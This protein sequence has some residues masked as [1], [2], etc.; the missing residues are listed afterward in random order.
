MLAFPGIFRGALDA[1]AKTINQKMKMDAALA[2]SKCV[3]KPR[4]DRIL[5][6]P[7]KKSN[8]MKVAN[9]VKRAAI[10]SRA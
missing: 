1:R 2:L 6:P 4:I 9:A 8:A 7:L 10:K 5:P 3:K